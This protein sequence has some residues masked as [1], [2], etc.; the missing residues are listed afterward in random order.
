ML[1]ETYE[2][3]ET[4]DESPEETAEAVALMEK[5]GLDAQLEAAGKSKSPMGRNPYREMTGDEAFVFGILCPGRAKLEQYRAGP[6][7]LRV[8][9]IASHAMDLG[10]FDHLEVWHA[11]AVDVKDPMLVGKCKNKVSPWTFDDFILARWGD[12]LDEW[13]ALVKTAMAKWR[14]RVRAEIAGVIGSAQQELQSIDNADLSVAIRTRSISYS[15][16]R[17]SNGSGAIIF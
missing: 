7:P 17:E 6:I 14:D 8:L 1:V 15:G 11:T 5:L 16:L 13:P 10:I 9:Q 2:C 3:E 4:R 12:V